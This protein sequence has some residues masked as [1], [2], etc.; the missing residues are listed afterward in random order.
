MAH[1]L[2]A[3]TPADLGYDMAWV[4]GGVQQVWGLGVPTWRLPYEALAK[5][6]GY[7]AFPDRLA[8]NCGHSAPY[9]WVGR[10]ISST[11]T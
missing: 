10:A 1:L 5:L 11:R 8:S 4:K 2:S 3:M 7:D 6:F 9:L